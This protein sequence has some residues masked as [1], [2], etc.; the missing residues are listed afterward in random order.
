MHASPG[1]VLLLSTHR[2]CRAF[3]ATACS[4]VQG[5]PCF[6]CVPFG[7][8]ASFFN[9]FCKLHPFQGSRFVVIPFLFIGLG[10]ALIVFVG[11]FHASAL[12]QFKASRPR[13]FT[14]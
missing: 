1:W 11:S 8:G 2:S 14:V 9:L 6:R 5:S 3:E 10:F 4:T 7:L 13:S 12:S